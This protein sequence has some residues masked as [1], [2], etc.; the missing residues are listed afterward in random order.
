MADQSAI[1]PFLC[2]I[3]ANIT[4]SSSPP[5]VMAGVADMASQAKVGGLRMFKLTEIDEIDEMEQVFCFRV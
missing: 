4:L 2:G 5:V 1:S 3:R